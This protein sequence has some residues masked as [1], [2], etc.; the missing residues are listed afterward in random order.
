MGFAQAVALLTP[1]GELT[2]VA[3]VAAILGLLLLVV[4]ATR[5]GRGLG[6][7]HRRLA[8]RLLGE[9]VAPPPPLRSGRGPLGRLGAGLRD[10]P[11]WRS[12][13][14]QLL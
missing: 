13:A 4:L 2:W 7:V 1:G 8:A 12:V 5:V 9:R 3:G 10:G 6:A 11:G 14:Y